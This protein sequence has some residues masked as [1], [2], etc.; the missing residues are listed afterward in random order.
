MVKPFEDAAC[1][2]RRGQGQ[3]RRARPSSASTSSRSTR[4]PRT[5]TPRSSAAS[6][7]RPRSIIGHESER[8]AAEG[9]KKILAAV[10]GGKTLND[11]LQAHLDEV[12]P[13]VEAPAKKD[14]KKAKKDEKKK[15]DDAER[16]QARR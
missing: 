10:R 14:E 16:R 12:L 5:P 8:L 2:A 7:R 3:R 13:K 11:A 6:R 9:A 1:R 4:S 15:D